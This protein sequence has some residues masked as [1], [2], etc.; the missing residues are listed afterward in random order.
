MEGLK[1]GLGGKVPL[2]VEMLAAEEHG[3]VERVRELK[4]SGSR[5]NLIIGVP[6]ASS[7]ELEVFAG[8][9]WASDSEHQLAL[10]L[11]RKRDL[12]KGVRAHVI[13]NQRYR[14]GRLAAELLIRRIKGYRGEM[15]HEILH[16]E[17]MFAD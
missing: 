9:P 1:V 16:H 4:E 11:Q 13:I 15:C 14:M 17:I 5:V 2:E 3:V 8:E 6:L 7:S 10:V 12:P